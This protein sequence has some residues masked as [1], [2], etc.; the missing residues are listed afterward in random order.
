MG[1]PPSRNGGEGVGLC[2]DPGQ[3]AGTRPAGN[4][5]LAEGRAGRIGSRK[6][7]GE[8]A[9]AQMAEAV[10][11]MRGPRAQGHHVPCPHG[12][13]ERRHPGARGAPGRTL[14]QAQERAR[15]GRTGGGRGGMPARMCRA[16]PRGAPTGGDA[17]EAR[18]KKSG[19]RRR[20]RHGRTHSNPAA[21]RL[22]D[23]GRRQAVHRARGR[24][25]APHNRLRR[26]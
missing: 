21:R 10:A 5:R 12:Q 17:A 18:P 6:R 20:A 24:R 8:T 11:G 22:R 7:G 16:A 15:G 2:P 1:D 14:V 13:A 3:R 19:Q 25:L 23:A 4:A 9:S 26:A